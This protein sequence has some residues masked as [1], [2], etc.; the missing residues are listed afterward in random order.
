MQMLFNTKEQV[1]KEAYNFGSEG[2]HKMGDKRMPCSMYKHNP[3]K[4]S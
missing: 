2:A 3:L 4:R 1:E